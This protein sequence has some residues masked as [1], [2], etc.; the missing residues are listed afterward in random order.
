MQDYPWSAAYVAAVLEV[1]ADKMDHKI[2]RAE[3][4][5]SERRFRGSQVHTEELRCMRRTLA[6]LS[7]LRTERVPP[8][9]RGPLESPVCLLKKP[10]LRSCTSLTGSIC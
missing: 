7:V 4:A 2:S 5:I 6:A 8:R 9:E 1:D 10:K 3:R